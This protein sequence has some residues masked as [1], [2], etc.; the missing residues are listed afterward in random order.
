MNKAWPAAC[1]DQEIDHVV[2]KALS[3][4]GTGDIIST[5]AT[6]AQIRRLAP[7]CSR[8]DDELVALLVMEATGRAIAVSFDHR[9]GHAG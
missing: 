8:S 4:L 3:G 7:K 1:I 2:S 5:H 6:I 9:N